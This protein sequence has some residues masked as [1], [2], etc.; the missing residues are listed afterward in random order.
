MIVPDPNAASISVSFKVATTSNVVTKVM[1]PLAQV[2]S[3]G[4]LRVEEPFDGDYAS[5]TM[6]FTLKWKPYHS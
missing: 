5:G 6:S 4:D 3:S 2:M 1:V